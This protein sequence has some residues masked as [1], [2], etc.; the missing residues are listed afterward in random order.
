MFLNAEAEKL[1][2]WTLTEASHKP[3]KMI[4]RIIN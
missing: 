2:G 1:T 4:F 3:L